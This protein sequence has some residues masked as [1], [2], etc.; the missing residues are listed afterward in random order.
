MRPII[1]GFMI[2][3][4][5]CFNLLVKLSRARKRSGNKSEIV[6]VFF[7]EIRF[8]DQ[9]IISLRLRKS[10][11]QKLGIFMEFHVGLDSQPGD[12][13]SFTQRRYGS[14]IGNSSFNK[15]HPN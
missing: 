11:C 6:K 15:N 3:I 5:V 12:R 10:D 13:Y 7:V 8:V 2:F 14:R 9:S 4:S 1:I